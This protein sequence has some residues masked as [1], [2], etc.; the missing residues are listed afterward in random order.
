M[1]GTVYGGRDSNKLN[2]SAHLRE[3]QQRVRLLVNERFQ[4]MLLV[5]LQK[6]NLKHLFF[7]LSFWLFVHRLIGESGHFYPFKIQCSGLG[8]KMLLNRQTVSFNKKCKTK[9][10]SGYETQTHD[11]VNIC[12]TIRLI[13]QSNPSS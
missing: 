7:F 2:A 5:S 9:Y 6:R 11:G 12:K 1:C 8:L 10:I 4:F 13:Y 3:P